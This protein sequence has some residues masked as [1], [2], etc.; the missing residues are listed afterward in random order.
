MD[1]DTAQARERLTNARQDLQD[2]IDGTENGDDDLAAQV[3]A[4]AFVLTK[5]QADILATVLDDLDR[6]TARL[7]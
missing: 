2:A 7:P 4:R 6:I 3:S 1:I 5:V